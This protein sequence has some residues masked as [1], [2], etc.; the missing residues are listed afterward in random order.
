V[1]TGA[2]AGSGLAGLQDRID[3]LGGSLAVSSGA[4][5]TRLSAVLPCGW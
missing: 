1:S 3:L 5:G 4:T 2:R